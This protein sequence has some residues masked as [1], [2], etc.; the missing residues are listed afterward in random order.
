MGVIPI[1]FSPDVEV[2]IKGMKRGNRSQWVNKEV[3]KVIQAGL[4]DSDQRRIVEVS[5]IHLIGTSINRVQG[6]VVDSKSFDEEKRK[7]LLRL[8]ELGEMCKDLIEEL[9][10]KD[11]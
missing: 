7:K 9:V 5:A 8:K 1:N 2:F 10:P 4:G 3:K 6:C 11:L